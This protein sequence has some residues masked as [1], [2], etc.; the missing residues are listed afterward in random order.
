M[1]QSFSYLTKASA[2]KKKV[3]NSISS[4][5]LIFCREHELSLKS[6]VHLQLNLLL[7]I[8]HKALADSFGVVPT[9]NVSLPTVTAAIMNMTMSN[10]VCRSG[11][12][13]ML[14]KK[15]LNLELQAL[16]Q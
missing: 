15:R 5:L 11:S 12:D 10:I 9:S 6:C 8:H 1:L 2:K 7:T 16:Y 3:I 13:S 14:G 4:L